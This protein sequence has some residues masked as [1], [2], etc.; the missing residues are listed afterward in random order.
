MKIYTRTGD[1][2]LTGLYGGARVAKN[3]VRIAAYGTVDE[4]NACLG[5]C[6]A[7]GL[8]GEVDRLLGQLQHDMFALGAELASPGVAA[9]GSILLDETDVAR[10]EA[11]IDQYDAVLAPLKTFVLP[12][13]TPASA[14]LHVA[15][16]VCRRAERDVVTLSQSAEVRPELLVY[17]N[18]VGDLLFVLA[19]Y[20]NHVAGVPD[21]LWIKKDG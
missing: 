20:S 10:V 14:A 13:G 16:A 18:R 1:A 8:P 6:R 7:A 5:S 4:L 15:R 19:R 2:G 11:A 9:P 3:N 21:V 17:L 12:G